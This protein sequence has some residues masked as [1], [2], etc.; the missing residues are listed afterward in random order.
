M[1]KAFS[2]YLG[3]HLSSLELDE[4]FNRVDVDKSGMIDYSEFIIAAMSQNRLLSK[5][6]L[7]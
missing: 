6:K 7:S 4:M 2:E 5:K 3:K 1:K